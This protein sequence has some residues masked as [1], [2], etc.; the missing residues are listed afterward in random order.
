MSQPTENEEYSLLGLIADI[1]A[2]VGDP[3]GKLMQDELVEHCRRLREEVEWLRTLRSRS[4]KKEAAPETDEEINAR[5]E[6]W[7]KSVENIDPFEWERKNRTARGGLTKKSIVGIGVPW[8]PKRPWLGP[9]K[10]QWRNNQPFCPAVL[11]SSCCEAGLRT[12]GGSEGTNYHVCESC[13]KPC[14]VVSTVP[15]T[16]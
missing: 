1:R 12:E 15:S 4:K 3:M 13:G 5:M 14:D 9:W 6:A 7:L 11:E 16:V 10:M 8:P 2:A